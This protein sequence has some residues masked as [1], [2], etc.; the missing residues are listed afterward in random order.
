MHPRQLERLPW[1]YQSPATYFLY[2]RILKEKKKKR[3]VGV[4]ELLKTHIMIDGVYVVSGL[5]VEK[6]TNVETKC[7][8]RR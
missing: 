6:T 1:S 2:L 7:G 3:E 4:V 5:H 8:Q